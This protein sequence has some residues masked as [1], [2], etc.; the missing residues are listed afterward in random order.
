M[1][2]QA[3]EQFAAES[4]ELRPQWKQSPAS[5]CFCSHVVCCGLC[6]LPVTTKILQYSIMRFLLV[7]HPN[8]KVI[9]WMWWTNWM[10]LLNHCCKALTDARK[11]TRFLMCFGCCAQ[12]YEG[13]KAEQFDGCIAN[14]LAGPLMEL[15]PLISAAVR[16]GGW[17]AMS[18]ILASQVGKPT[19]SEKADQN[20]SKPN[21]TQ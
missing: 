6:R 13:R 21:P 10:P 2:A 8:L 19:L 7:T 5:V 18:G 1:P 3:N 4:A 14:I 20:Q 9:V 12:E 16:P 15:A 11:G 17:L